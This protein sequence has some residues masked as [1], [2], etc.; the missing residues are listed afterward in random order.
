MVFKNIFIDKKLVTISTVRFNM[1]NMVNC[2][3]QET[4][5]EKVLEKLHQECDWLSGR[6]RWSVN[7]ITKLDDVDALHGLNSKHRKSYSKFISGMTFISG[8]GKMKQSLDGIDKVQV[9]WRRFL[10]MLTHTTR[11]KI[12]PLCDLSIIEKLNYIVHKK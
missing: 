9:L 12:D 6:N 10:T 11:S 8:L 3:I 4:E 7:I 2:I 1:L 5:A